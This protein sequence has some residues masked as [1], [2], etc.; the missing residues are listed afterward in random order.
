MDTPT[1]SA[2]ASDQVITD[3]RHQT[4]L[5]HTF[6]ALVEYAPDAFVVTDLQGILTYVNPAFKRLYGYGDEAIGM[7][8]P[9][10]FPE[11]E[12][13]QLGEMLEIIQSHGEWQGVL[14]HRRKDGS[15]FIAQETAYFIRGPDETPLAMAAIIRDVTAQQQAE[16]ELR[17]LQEQVIAAQ[18]VALAELSTPL[19]PIND[20]VMVMPLIG[21]I[22]A[23]RAQQI[24]ATLL[25]GIADNRAQVAILDITGVPVVDTQ[26]ANALIQAAQS[27][28]LLGAQ[29]ILTGIRPEVAQTLVGLGVDLAGILTAN[30]LQSGIALAIARG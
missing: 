28:A 15:T 21:T 23:Q 10:F 13:E 5:L 8:I 6:K 27:V 30:S 22:D 24:I 19:I 2:S 14:F 1:P 16:Q 29:V 12:L 11:T 3:Q 25:Q 7:P 17:I 26:V 9:D 20:Q 4:A 18:Q